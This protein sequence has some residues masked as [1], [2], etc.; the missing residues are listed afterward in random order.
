MRGQALRVRTGAAAGRILLLA[1]SLSAFL[2]APGLA[3]L[4]AEGTGHLQRVP[5]SVVESAARLAVLSRLPCGAG[6]GGCDASVTVAVACT[7]QGQGRHEC[8]A[9]SSLRVAGIPAM[10]R[11][12][13][14]YSPT[15]GTFT[16][17]GG[18]RL[19]PEGGLPAAV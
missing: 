14:V 3:A 13:G 9:A 4:P 12:V 7:A 5:S 15:A 16:I 19:L 18:R 8:V 10:F 17:L 2:L 1:A 6:G 11:L